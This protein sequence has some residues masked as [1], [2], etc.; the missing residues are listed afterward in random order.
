[1]APAAE[2]TYY[3]DANGIRRLETA[4]DGPKRSERDGYRH[5]VGGEETDDGETGSRTVAELREALDAASVEYPASAK[6]ADL[7]KLAA[8]NGV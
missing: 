8:D 6:K 1:M 2:R 4:G 7:E 3:E 5:V